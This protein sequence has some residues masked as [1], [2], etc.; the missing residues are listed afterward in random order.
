MLKELIKNDIICHSFYL[1]YNH[2]MWFILKKNYYNIEKNI[3]KI[4]RGDYT[5]FLDPLTLNKVKNI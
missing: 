3:N 2:K 4:Y 5:N 1:C